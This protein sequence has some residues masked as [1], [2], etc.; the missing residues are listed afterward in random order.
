MTDD[1]AATR[2]RVVVVGGGH[3]GGTFV[4]L[5]RQAGHTGEI[6]VVGAEAHPPYQRPPLSKKLSATG[7]EWLRPAQFYA[8]NDVTLALGEHVTA[9]DRAARTVDTSLGRILAYDALVLATGARPRRLHVPGSDLAGVL[10][11]RTLDDA[12]RLRTSVAAGG[13]LAVVG[14][15][16]VGLEVAAA[17]RAGGVPVT[18]VEREDRVLARVAS[19]A[20]SGILTDHHVR[21]GTTVLTGAEVVAFEGDGRRV[22]GIFLADGTSVAADTAVVGVGAVPCDDLANAARLR[23]SGG[24][25]VDERARTSDPA[26]WAIGDVTVRPHHAGG[27]PMRLESIPSATEQAKQAVA[28]ILGRPPAAL[29]VPW[30]WSDQLDLKLKIA[31]VVRAPYDTVL[32]GDPASGSFALFHHLGDRLVAVEAANANADFMAGRRMLTDR[33]AVDPVRL[34]DP[35]VALRELALA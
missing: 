5:L 16:Y 9:I 13:P 10:T 7:A 14:G 21:H 18:V 27:A 12:A 25:V 32:R 26:V 2:S 15:G 29:E 20:L 24:V 3:A 23:C 35:A 11:L 6:V 22:H 8:D 31:G 33:R 17:A 19:P 30:F 4:A 1:L 28:S 34:A